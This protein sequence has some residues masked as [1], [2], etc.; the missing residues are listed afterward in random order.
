MLW[1]NL[2]IR[3]NRLECSVD[4]AAIAAK[5]DFIRIETT[6]SYLKSGALMLDAPLLEN[7][8]CAVRF[9]SRKS[10]LV[11]MNRDEGNKAKLKQVISK[12]EG[13]DCITIKTVDISEV[14][15]FELIQ[16]LLNALS[17]YD[18]PELSFNN[19]TGH[20]YCFHPKWIKKSKGV[21]WQVPCM[22]MRISEEMI[23]SLNIRTFTS[24]KLQKDITFKKK[25]YHDYPK[26]VFSSRNT[27]RRKLADDKEDEFILRQLNGE[28]SDVGFLDTKS[29]EAFKATKMGVLSSVVDSFNE[30]YEGLAHVEFA[31]ENPSECI[32]HDLKAKKENKK[33]VEHALKLPIRL[34]DKVNDEHSQDFL[35]RV[36]SVLKENWNIEAA[37]GP[38]VSKKSLNVVLIHDVDYYEN[39]DDPHSRNYDATVQHITHEKYDGDSK[40]AAESIIHELLIKEDLRN[41]KISLF[42][43]A[44]FNAGGDIA[45][46]MKYVD[47][48]ES[49]RYFFMLI[50]PD[51]SFEIDEQV[52][53]LFSQSR[54]SACMEI[55]DK[56]DSAKENVKGVVM[57]SEGYINVIK[58]TS[59]ITIP[60][61][62]AIKKELESGNN[63]LR[64]KAKRE[65][66]LSSCLDIKSFRIDGTLHYFV[67]IIGEGMKYAIHNAANIRSIV[68]YGGAPEFFEKLLPLMNVS[69][70][71]NEQLT[72]I[73]FPFKYL[74][75][76][77]K[78]HIE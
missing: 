20:L 16:L 9:D 72:V 10:L 25:K 66:L 1:E 6:E 52:N 75:E 30:S 5:Y 78:M 67:G 14:K 64:S 41:G 23:L 44:H 45:F 37:I 34:V 61:I 38:N 3:T 49:P 22:E 15:K 13:F 12:I 53:D 76:W 71:K 65:E 24:G 33:A 58:D 36:Q 57:N 68:P 69:F 28:K 19:L 48:E 17:R 42:D 18:L 46:G 29:L 8:T 27:L 21:I 73:P 11:M 7:N 35:K 50:H 70:V 31:Q 59:W 32:D 62:L 77:I 51:G 60:E 26:Y 54:Y 63:K 74:R 40:F 39:M 2:M 56:A 47:D 43:W 55:F 4:V